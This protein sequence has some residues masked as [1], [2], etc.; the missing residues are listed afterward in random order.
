MIYELFTFI[1][2][3]YDED[4]FQIEEN[5]LYK[6]VCYPETMSLDAKHIISGLLERDPKNRLGNKNSPHGLLS[7]QSFF[8]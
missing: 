4:D 2:P 6:D 8:R 7:E 3:F 5:V 1:T